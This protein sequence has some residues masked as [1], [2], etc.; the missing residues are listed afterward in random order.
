M[1]NSPLGPDMFDLTGKVALVTGGAGIQGQRIT[2]GLASFGAD[3]AV[4]D[5]DKAAALQLAEKIKQEYDVQAMLH[6]RQLER[7]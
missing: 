7:K 1:T 4:V 3:V 2:R 6:M 5:I